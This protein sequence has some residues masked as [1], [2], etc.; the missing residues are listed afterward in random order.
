IF[1]LFLAVLWKQIVNKKQAIAICFTLVI[2]SLLMFLAFL[3]QGYGILSI[4]LSTLH[5]FVEYWAAVFI[6]KQVK[7][8]RPLHNL[9]ALFIKG[10]LIALVISSLG[11]YA[12]AVISAN[13]W[14]DY[15]IFDMAVYFYLHFQYN[16]WL[17]L[18][19]IGLF[20]MIL[21]FKKIHLHEKMFQ[22]G[23]WIYFSALFPNYLLSVMWVEPVGVFVHVVGIIGSVGQWLGVLTIIFALKKS[24]IN[25]KQHFSK[26]T[27][28]SLWITLF[29]L[30]VKST[31]ELGLIFPNLAELVYETRSVIIGYL[32][33][34]LLGFISIF[35]LTL[36]F[37]QDFLLV[38]KKSSL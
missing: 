22:L 1:L 19:L 13:G 27:R 14:K 34:T 17:T 6:Y 24:H 10:A 3:Y 21:R 20:I 36:F 33:V 11:P 18:C 4:I 16:G 9:S 28:F 15:A 38:N 25:W 2:V 35:I 37:I 23:F 30:L 8:L 31:M 5:I 32:H 12:L 7:M 26:L 29:L